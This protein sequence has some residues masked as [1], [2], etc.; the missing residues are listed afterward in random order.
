MIFRQLLERLDERL[1]DYVWNDSMNV[2]NDLDER[3]AGFVELELL[4]E[5]DLLIECFVK[6]LELELSRMGSTGF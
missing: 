1:D 3:L 2:W 5:L 4:V 6:L